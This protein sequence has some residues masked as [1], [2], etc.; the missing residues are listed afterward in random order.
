MSYALLNQI[1][2]LEVLQ[3]VEYRAIILEGLTEILYLND[4]KQLRQVLEN[5][6]QRKMSRL[7]ERSAHN[8]EFILHVAMSYKHSPDSRETVT[9]STETAKETF[10]V[11]KTLQ[12]LELQIRGV[13]IWIDQNMYRYPNRAM[14]NE[15]WTSYLV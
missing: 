1:E 14:S 2:C 11:L 4:E 15:K 3:A 6:G 13:W 12:N 9:I 10:N 7:D 5:A 8:D